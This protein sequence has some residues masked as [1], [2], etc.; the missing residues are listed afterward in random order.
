MSRTLPDNAAKHS[1]LQ[2]MYGVLQSWD[3]ECELGSFYLFKCVSHV[4][5]AI[6]YWRKLLCSTFWA[7]YVE[8]CA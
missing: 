7:C 2:N 3:T 1:S 8:N 4:Q 6:M 5:A